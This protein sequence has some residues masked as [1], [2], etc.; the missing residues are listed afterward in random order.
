M[1]KYQILMISFFVLCA[2]T[3]AEDY[4]NPSLLATDIIG[5]GNI[6]L[7]AFSR[8]GGGMEG[9]R[10]VTIYV[11]NNFY[12]RRTLV[13]KNTSDKGLLPEFTPGFFDNL[14][15]G[16][17]LVSEKNKIISS[18]DFLK[19]VPYSDI[20]F[21]QGMSRV[22]VSIPQA[23]LGDGAKLISSPDT[24]E[25]GVPAFLLDY[26]ISGNRNASGN[27]DS[28]S[29]YISSQM[30]VNLMKWHLR[31]S[32]SY[33]NY[34]T[35]SVW[36]GARSERN[37][38]YNTYAERDI[39]SLRAV[40]R[41][42]EISTRG[43]I[44]D[45]VPF[46]GVK[47]SSSDDMLEARLRN[48][49]PTVRGMARSQAV[50]TIT[51][52]GRQ[53]YQTNVPAG[54]FELND[55]YLSG[56]SGDMQ[57][58]V[59]EA[60]G[61]EHSFLQPYSTLPEM[62]R[63]GISGFEIS[64]G[65][66]DNNGAEH[67]YDAES[68][69]Y[70]NWSRGFARGVTF[71]GETLQAEKYQSLGVGSTL[72]LGRLGASSADISL[73]RVDKYGAIRG[74]QS[75]GFKYSKS[76]IE[77]GTTLT[78]ATYRYSTEHFYTF[79]DFVSKTDTAR[80]VW[81]NKLKNR[82]TLSLSQ[83]LGEYGYLSA[84]ASKQDYWT[85]REVSRNYALTHSFNWNDIYLSTT[86]S[87]DDQ[88]GREA[89]DLSNKQAGLYVTVPLNKFLLGIDST[90]SSL[91]WSTSHADHNV[92]NSVT[93]NGKMPESDVR[94]RVGGSWGNGNTEGSRTVS[95]SWSGDYVSTSLGYARTGKYRTLD[96]NMS[97]AAVMYPW[98]IAMGNNS[99][100]GDGA[101]VVETPGA[102]GVRTSTGYRTS[103]L[104]TSLVSSP[105]KYTENR[106]DLYPDGLPD[107]TV[108]GETSKT[109]VP[110][111]GAVVVLDYTVFRG[112][113]VVFT[114]RQSNGK[115]LPFGT[116][117][118]LDGVSR[119]KENSGI[120]GEEGRVYMAGMPEKGTLTATW[121]Q[122]K[123]CSVPFRINQHKTEAVISEIHGVCRV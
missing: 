68:F 4:F 6:D 64:V 66:Y 20:N 36:G 81:E 105:R 39:S 119:G 24:W 67:Y 18:S 3:F 117:V 104:G 5:E 82:M 65:R 43:L 71:F 11:N 61:S 30:G 53:V 9:E 60:D 28:R 75:Y 14:V 123:S 120:V 115:P 79:R 63:E 85:S 37:S 57:V 19:K 103:W 17:V 122:D 121:G 38:F 51:Q 89:G 48:Y 49:T 83:S 98:G 46:R 118:T 8:P 47:L 44:L 73:S 35:N 15:S 93:L 97:G 45:S 34:K 114:L 70:G 10:E 21:D 91:T 23:Y 106:I 100:T 26:N 58:T 110:V 108:L 31:T 32:S 76:Q 56:Y 84:S 25:Y 2:E 33:S 52:N 74:G 88:R 69:V 59:R 27:N 86:L 62:K 78:L 13:F 7:S 1:H 113:Q 112:R 72:S 12:S 111:K 40:L 95:V 107:D 42:G 22:N 54:P 16:D 50:V 109:T 55:F 96:Y 94:Y 80:Y 87:M 101:I 92:R 99:V 102:K 29:L 116:V 90:G 77:T 41:L